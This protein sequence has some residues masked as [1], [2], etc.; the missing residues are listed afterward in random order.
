MAMIVEDGGCEAGQRCG[1]VDGCRGQVI[2]F[3]GQLLLV[4]QVVAPWLI[5]SV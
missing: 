1:A 5:G 2:Q 4:G 3:D